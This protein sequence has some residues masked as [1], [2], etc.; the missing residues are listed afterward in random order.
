MIGYSRTRDKSTLALVFA[1]SVG[2]LLLAGLLLALSGG[3]LYAA[4]PASIAPPG[5]AEWSGEGEGFGSSYGYAVSGVGDVDKDGY[6]DFIVGAYLKN[7][8]ETQPAPPAD[9]NV[10]KVYLYKGDAAGLN[11]SASLSLLGEAAA[12]WFGYEVAAAGD[13][14]H[15]GVADF[16]VSALRADAGGGL[17][18]TGKV[19]IYLGQ[20]GL[21]P[22]LD[23]AINGEAAGDQFG[24][25]V[26]AAGDVNGDG[27]DDIIVGAKQNDA[28]GQDAG[29]AYVYLGSAGGIVTASVLG[30]EGEEAL[31]GFGVAVGAAGDVNGDGYGDVIVGAWQND[32]G[33]QNAGKVYVYHGGAAGIS[34]T[35]V[36]TDVGKDAY[37]NFGTSVGAAG[38]VNG[39]GYGDVIVGAPKNPE[40]GQ[41]A[42]KV[43]VYLG[44]PN[45]LV[46]P[47]RLIVTGE[48]A[49]DEFGFAVGAAGDVNGDGFDDLTVGAHRYDVE[50]GNSVSDGGRVYLYA[51]CVDAPQATPI[52]TAT[53]EANSSHLGRAISAAGDVNHDGFDD[54]GA[55]AYGLFGKAYVY[56]GAAGVGACTAHIAVSQSVGIAGFGPAYS[57]AT[58]LKVPRNTPV[59]YG[60]TVQNVG[61]TTLR[62]HSLSDSI[63]GLLLDHAPADLAPGAVHAH[64]VTITV[65]ADRLTQAAWT[66]G[67]LLLAPG[68]APSTPPGKELTATAASAITVTVSLDGE[69]S[70]GDGIPDNTEGVVD[71]DHDGIPAF[72]DADEQFTG[73]GDLYLPMIARQ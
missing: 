57:S 8:T 3:A 23:K 5:A 61:A 26:A 16:L 19:Y 60:Y 34:A 21:D 54:L 36:F 71:T 52:F 66:S 11:A 50:E 45:G 69:D 62:R 72:L 39:D 30:M 47:P 46:K 20:D 70:D 48:H 58:S 55:G 27:F 56:H 73:V 32:E 25:D 9:A 35:P 44:G 64:A 41:Y 2:A 15:D 40:D 10:G 43:Y 28:G 37:S 49:D 38:D 14:N 51:G 29:K 17:T 53:G 33:G 65:A 4:R 63:A 42:G 1:S 31:D 67:V 12:D 18:D 22:I 6:D 7:R 59:V 24:W 68:G 13:I